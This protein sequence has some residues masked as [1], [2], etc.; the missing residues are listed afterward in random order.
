[1]TTSD[2]Q[3]PKAPKRPLE[4]PEVPVKKQKTKLTFAEFQLDNADLYNPFANFPAGPKG[5]FFH[6]NDFHGHACSETENDLMFKYFNQLDVEQECRELATLDLQ[7]N[8]QTSKFFRENNY[9][10]K[11]RILHDETERLTD[12]LKT[13]DI[14]SQNIC[15]SMMKTNL[16]QEKCFGF[17]KEVFQQRIPNDITN[18]IYEYVIEK[19]PEPQQVMFIDDS[20]DLPFI[21]TD[22]ES[23]D[24]EIDWSVPSVCDTCNTRLLTC[25]CSCLC[26]CDCSE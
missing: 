16:Y 11:D 22:D 1:M 5:I 26:N 8:K 4:Q 17:L 18:L 23:S 2:Y 19:K 9:S 3:P 6:R 20:H 25:N 15:E 13:L 24:D 14:R 10:E 12:H 7:I 21:I